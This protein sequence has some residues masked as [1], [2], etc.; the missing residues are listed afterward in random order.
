MLK[1]LSSWLALSGGSTAD[2]AGR[3]PK[4]AVS[5]RAAGVSAWRRVICALVL[6]PLAMAVA[7]A[8]ERRPLSVLLGQPAPALSQDQPEAWLNSEPLSW[9]GLRGK[10]V[11][12]QFWTFACWNCYRSI[13][14]LN[15]LED[16]FGRERFAILSV[17]TPEL[18]HE[19]DRRRLLAKIAEHRVAYPAMIDN[20][21]S[22]WDA[23]QNRYWPAFYLV[24]AQGRVR[25][26]YIGETHAGDANARRI[27]SDIA[28]VLEASS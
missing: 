18:P 2:R 25:G 26:Y 8:V 3:E 9:A 20:D 6:V 5:A 28:R 27:E 22:Y 19:Y 12:L 4:T 1:A 11:L 10:V 21:H 15:T 13:P 7:Q 16:R 23:M 14:W 24:D 17:H